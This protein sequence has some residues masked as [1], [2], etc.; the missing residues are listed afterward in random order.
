MR[1]LLALLG[2]FCAGCAADVAIVAS[3]RCD[4][5][6]PCESG[7]ICLDGTCVQPGLGTASGLDV[8]ITPPDGAPF[9]KSQMFGVAFTPEEGPTHLLLP[10]AVYFSQVTLIDA[11][12]SPQ[13]ARITILGHDRIPGHEVDT[14]VETTRVRPG[15][16]RLVPGAYEARVLPS[17]PTIPGIHVPDWVVRASADPDQH[18]SF[19][20]PSAYRKLRG[21]VR[22]RTSMLTKLGGVTVSARA[23]TSGLPSTRVTTG[24]DGRFELWLPDTK[25]N[26]FEVTA[27]PSD[28]NDLPAWSFSEEIAVI[29]NTEFVIGL[30]QSSDAVRG[31]LRLRVLGTGGVA[32]EGVANAHVTLTA[33]TS[34]AYRSF[35][36]EGTTDAMGYFVPGGASPQNGVQILAARY[37]V[38][39]EPDSTS[40]YQ[41]TAVLL[42]LPASG[43]ALVDKQIP[44]T[45][46]AH[47]RGTVRS[48]LG[49]RVDGAALRFESALEDGRTVN[50]ATDAEGAFD[51]ALSPGDY[52]VAVSPVSNSKVNEILPPTAVRVTVPADALAIDLPP[53]TLGRGTQATGVVVGAG[54]GIAGASIEIFRPLDGRAISLG[55]VVSEADG[56]FQ[57]ALPL[58]QP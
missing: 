52:L 28:P 1:S 32:P 25:D 29:D 54:A 24:P 10:A 50:A 34:L 9:A 18:R 30:E 21:E 40:P 8:E 14:V 48:R 46:K 17:D 15:S 49:Q 16:V 19:Q 47:V 42:D 37:L 2:L 26:R 55:R 45:P 23:V 5:S 22:L 41:S 56:S 36:L 53:L 33:S 35:R 20:I 6:A 31:G 38:E 7:L 39:I 51:V 12:L 11:N 3:Y 4:A 57:L 58:D 43:A 13:P 44:L 27:V